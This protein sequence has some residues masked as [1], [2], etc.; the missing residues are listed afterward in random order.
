MKGDGNQQDYGM[1]VYDPRLGRFLSVDPLQKKFPNES[2]YIFVS[3]SPL[4]YADKDGKEK[5]VT[6]IDKSGHKTIV[7]QVNPRYVEFHASYTKLNWPDIPG[8][9]FNIGAKQSVYENYVIDL[10]NPKNNTYSVDYKTEET[11][12]TS[13][14][15]NLAK[16]FNWINGDQSDKEK[17]GYFLMASGTDMGD[18]DKLERASAGSQILDIENLISVLEAFKDIHGENGGVTDYMM[19]EY[20]AKLYEYTERLMKGIEKIQQSKIVP[21]IKPNSK[22]SMVFVREDDY[23]TEKKGSVQSGAYVGDTVVDRKP[24][25]DGSGVDTAHIRR[26]AAKKTQN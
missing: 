13:T 12:Y 16:A 25:Q 14:G 22:K 2:N 21:E 7:K 10:S 18:A 20:T 23:G 9:S 17:I 3:N 1:R 5:I 24:A 15:Y 4:L 6:T 19:S 26:R 11:Y 8:T